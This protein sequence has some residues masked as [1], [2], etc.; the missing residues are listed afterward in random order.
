MINLDDRDFIYYFIKPDPRDRLLVTEA[1][2]YPWL[3][4]V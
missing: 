1:L 4:A 3:K 2:I